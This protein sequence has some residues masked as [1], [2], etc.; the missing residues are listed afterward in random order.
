MRTILLSFFLLITMS[1]HSQIFKTYAEGYYY[2]TSGEKVSGLIHRNPY[3]NYFHFKANKNASAD[4]IKISGIK[5][6][7]MMVS[8]HP[9]SLRAD[10]LLALTEEGD[11]KKTYFASLIIAT[12]TAKIYRKFK[13]VRNSGMVMS[14]GIPNVTANMGATGMQSAFTASPTYQLTASHSGGSNQDVIMY[15]KDGTTFELDKKNFKEVLSK[16]FADYTD[17]A[18][19]ISDG[20][21][22]FK[23][24]WE[25]IDYYQSYIDSKNVK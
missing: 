5:Y 15:E 14:S 3:D 2:T 23:S 19:R 11:V 4:K 24:V 17:F 21:Y 1:A 16:A 10:T 12:P 13:P 6:L 18:S 9:D 7:V 20:E 22:K 25:I 8:D